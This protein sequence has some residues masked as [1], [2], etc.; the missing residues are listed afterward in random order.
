MIK[1]ENYPNAYKEVYVILR[2]IKKE[3]LEKI[4]KSFIEMVKMNMNRDYKFEL[5]SNK[6]FEEQNLL[7]ETKVILAYIYMKYWGTS[8]QTDTIKKKFSQDIIKGEQSKPKYNPDELFNR[9]NNENVVQQKEVQDIQLVEYKK[10]NIFVKFIKKIK[11]FL[12]I[13]W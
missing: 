1:V 13:K 4:P 12:K 11:N 8:L 5:D 7:K 6:E 10:D 2:N 9:K 3:D